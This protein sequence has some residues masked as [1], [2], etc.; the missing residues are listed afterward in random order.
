M[1]DIRHTVYI[2]RRSTSIIKVSVA[3]VG[4]HISRHSKE[5][6]A[7]ALDK[8]LWVIGNKM[9]LKTVIPLGH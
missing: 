1:S 6:L 4:V 8:W 3:Y 7:W 2:K 9:L 5:E